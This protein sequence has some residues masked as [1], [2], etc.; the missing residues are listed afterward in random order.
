MSTFRE[1]KNRASASLLN[2]QLYD[3]LNQVKTPTHK[4]S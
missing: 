1:I 2:S 3:M 4:K